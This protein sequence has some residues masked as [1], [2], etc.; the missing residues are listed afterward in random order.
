MTSDP[1]SFDNRTFE[2]ILSQIEELA[3]SYLKNK[4]VYA[5]SISAIRNSRPT[6]NLLLSTRT[7]NE[8]LIARN[9][10]NLRNDVGIALSKI[11]ASFYMNILNRLN[12]LPK[13]NLIEFLNV[14]GFNLSSPIASRVPVSFKLADGAKEDVFIPSGTIVASDATDKHE[15]LIFETEE[16]MIA[17]RATISQ[18]YTVNK[19]TDAIYSHTKDLEEKKKDFK[20]FPDIAWSIQ[21]HIL[22]LGH[23]DLFN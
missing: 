9:T 10:E 8:S 22:Y 18:L 20:L 11:F 3:R 6:R 19:K 4:W 5:T 2:D 13:R 21:Q 12:K 14:M 1:P 16:N 7:T 23:Q 17:T 15:E